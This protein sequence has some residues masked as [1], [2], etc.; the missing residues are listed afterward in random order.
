MLAGLPLLTWRSAGSG[1][2]YP[3]VASYPAWQ[4]NHSAGISW[5]YIQRLNRIWSDDGKCY[6]DETCKQAM[7]PGEEC[8][9]RSLLTL[10]VL[11]LGLVLGLLLVLV[12]LLLLLLVLLLL[13]LL[14]L[15]FLPPAPLCWI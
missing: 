9:C 3:N 10:L 2:F 8:E 4:K 12:L 11:L 1:W 7:P 14:L 6:A 13:L 15:L 5:D